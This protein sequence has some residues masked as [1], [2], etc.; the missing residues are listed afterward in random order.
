MSET[1]RYTSGSTGGPVFVDVQDDR[2]IRVTPIELSEDDAPSWQI[3]A[4]GR[5]FSPPRKTTIAPYTAAIKS[6]VYSDKRI[7]TP[8]KRVDFDPKGERNCEN[9]G[10]SG[11]EPISWD[12]ALDIVCGE[13]K[14]IKREYG[15]AAIYYGNS[16]HQLWGNIG[17][18]FSSFNRFRAVLGGAVME[19]NPD[20]WEG[21]FWGG[22]Q[23]WGF[24]WR[25][26]LPE[27]YDLLEDALKNTEMI[28][29]WSSDPEA[30]SGIYSGF[31]STIR[32]QW[33]KDL[34][35]EMVFIDPYYNA[36]AQM[37]SDKWLAPRPGT[38]NCLALAIAYT[39]ITEGTYDKEYV[40]T[41]TTG[42]EAFSDYVLGKEDG[43]AKTPEWAEA[44]STIPARVIRALA[45]QW[46]SKKTMLAAGGLG[47]MGGA[48]RAFGGNEWA[49][50]MI[51]LIAMQ[52][53]GKPGVNLWSTTQGGP[54]N[55]DFVFP[56]YS[57]A[58]I[59]GQG[60]ANVR[61][62]A[63]MFAGR[64]AAPGHNPGQTIQRLMLPEAI[65]EGK[66]EWY[67]NS[68]DSP[69]AQFMKR[70]YPAPGQPQIQM[71]Y[72][73]GGSFMGTMTETNRYAKMYRT[74]KL[75][76]VVNQSIWMEGEA[77]FADIILPACTNFE[78][79]DISEFAGCSGYMPHDFSK[80]NH[81]VITLQK[82]CIE[83]LGQSKSDY[84]I[85]AEIC[86]RMGMYEV[87]TDGGK[88]ELDW[89]HQMYQASDLP[90]YISWDKFFEKGYFVVP[91]PENYK[92]TPA[93][94]W[95]AEGRDRDTPDWGPSPAFTAGDRKQLQTVSGKI[96]FEATT[97]KRFDIDPE[98][99]ALPKYIPSWE[100]HHSELYRK[101]PIAMISP[102][103]RFS[104]HTMMDCK[105]SFINDVDEHRTLVDGYYY[106][107]A[108]IN[109]ADAKARGI[110]ERDLIRLFNDR[111]SVI[112][113]AHITDRVAPGILHA[114]ESCSDYDPMG[115]PGEIDSID[116][117]GC[118][119]ILTSKR[120]ITP[121][122]SG[123]ASNS[124]LIDYEKWEGIK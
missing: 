94:R 3:D 8:L 58:G 5:S 81:R 39:W 83:P 26:G 80:C 82:K 106:L 14:R 22:I 66:A 78:R 43:I 112:C 47:G 100:G 119:N 4:R 11:Y 114:Y 54:C 98:R 57:E 123:M 93:L 44:E 16:S 23:S 117:A 105:D 67:P 10:Q 68:S 103:P 38:D 77:K 108:R 71:Y 90:K 56:G 41:K 32:R 60:A 17:Y 118:V 101:Y 96:E 61:W 51:L 62:S 42:F 28:V 7:L 104:M 35:V 84:D 40:T 19:N 95:Y 121:T 30:T 69:E 27:Q 13:M 59:S 99:P 45:R 86:R 115:T 113:C 24:T 25:L 36:T 116:R 89:V 110:A 29:F 73:F 1:K 91:L 107:T 92:A 20:S 124:C 79:W 97:L 64:N 37:F 15:T 33:L 122:S 102:H 74:D 18:R 2:I 120:T 31:E 85:F 50:L 76:F 49:R 9:R 63:R 75:P 21:W 72:R 65:L 48:C 55:N 88:T 52:G 111:G 12:E 70:R 53:C 87:Y 46:A 109:P 6:S 34:G